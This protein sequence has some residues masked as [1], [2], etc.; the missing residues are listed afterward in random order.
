MQLALERRHHFW[1][2]IINRTSQTNH[3]SSVL[4]SQLSLMTQ[5]SGVG[6]MN[7]GFNHVFLFL[8]HT[9]LPV[10]V[11]VI[12]VSF[13]HSTILEWC[14]PFLVLLRWLDLFT[15]DMISIFYS[16]GVQSRRTS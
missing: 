15:C 9:L 14:Q 5:Q 2:I 11:S 16:R 8:L 10:Y 13:V 3:H 4:L 1:N 6:L 12:K 7:G